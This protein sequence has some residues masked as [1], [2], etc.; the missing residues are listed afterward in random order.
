MFTGK[1]DIYMRLWVRNL[2][3]N[4]K[5][6]ANSHTHEEKQIFKLPLFAGE[7]LIPIICELYQTF[8]SRSLVRVVCT[9]SW[10]NRSFSIA[11]LDSANG[12]KS[13]SPIPL[14]KELSA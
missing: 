6:D 1:N 3:M 8:K 13:C 4:P 11:G 7:R 2:Q 10:T 9:T 5:L 12:Y 14:F